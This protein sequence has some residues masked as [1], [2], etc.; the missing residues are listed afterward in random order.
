MEAS[1]A[2]FSCRFLR[3]KR[4][5]GGGPERLEEQTTVFVQPQR[6]DMAPS[7]SCQTVIDPFSRQEI[8]S[9]FTFYFAGST[10][11]EARRKEQLYYLLL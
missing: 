11:W 9:Y 10:A 3:G 1:D 5:G 6:G 2:A 7:E 8:S 4:G